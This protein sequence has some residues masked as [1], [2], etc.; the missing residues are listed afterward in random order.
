MRKTYNITMEDW[1]SLNDTLEEQLRRQII[2][3]KKEIKALSSENA[4]LKTNVNQL[5]KL[6]YETLKEKK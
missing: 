5:Q 4:V 3:L 6:Y 1:G 2:A